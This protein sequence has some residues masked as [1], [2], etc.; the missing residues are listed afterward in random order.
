MAEATRAPLEMTVQTSLDGWPI[1]LHL[2]LP[3]ERVSAALARLADLGFTPRA[4]S[5]APAAAPSKPQRPRA[6]K[7][8]TDGTP[9]CPT[10][11]TPM[12]E[13]QHGWFCSRKAAEGEPANPKGYC[14]A[15]AD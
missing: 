10:H 8:D 11:G 12:R 14:S 4:P 15:V 3:A 9:L 1:D 5:P 2:S 6:T 13:G 7:F